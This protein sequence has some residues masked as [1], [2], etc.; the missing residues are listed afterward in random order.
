MTATAWKNKKDMS[1]FVCRM[2][3]PLKNRWKRNCS[4]KLDTDSVGLPRNNFYVVSVKSSK[5]GPSFNVLS[6][7]IA[8]IQVLPVFIQKSAKK[9]WIYKSLKLGFFYEFLGALSSCVNNCSLLC[10]Q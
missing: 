1:T 7:E 8:N 6:F 2:K 4:L 9:S 5:K 10:L 3:A